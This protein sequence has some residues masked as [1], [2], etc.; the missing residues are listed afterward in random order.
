MLF[1]FDIPL[2]VPRLFTD[3]F[4]A[5]LSAVRIIAPRQAQS[6]QNG[7]LKSFVRLNFPVNFITG[8]LAAVFFLLA[9]S[10]I[11]RKEVHD[12]TLGT[13]G[14]APIDVMAFFITLAYIAISIDASG[15]IKYLSF[16][17]LQKAGKT[18]HVLF[19]YLYIFF[20]ALGTA[21][22]NDPIILSGTPFLAYMTRVSANIK[23]PRAWIF[24]QFAIAN[25]A[26]AI[27]VSSNPTNLVLA[28]AFGIKFINYTVNM[29]I[30]V[31]ST[32]VILF[33]C[34]LY[35]IF[36]KEGLIPKTIQMHELSE[37]AQ[38]RAPINPNI[39]YARGKAEEE[40]N[41]NTDDAQGQSLSLEEI[42]NPY[43][44][45]RSAWFVSPLLFLHPRD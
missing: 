18:G 31:I 10:A 6:G 16:K 41:M 15:L 42:M 45:K 30:P 12:G 11:G 17:V 40:E 38:A 37:E 5:A 2:L 14:I 33:P 36:R 19:L 1:P 34:L 3:G 24:T 7:K 39:P 25:V 13:D 21:I 29:I 23:H 44:D 20:F 9:I 35:I 32:V 4:L 8:P 22:G 27:L 43:L 26:S 28:G